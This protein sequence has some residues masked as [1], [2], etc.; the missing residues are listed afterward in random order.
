MPEGKPPMPDVTIDDLAQSY[1]NDEER[2]LVELARCVQVN[3]ENIRP[4]AEAHALVGIAWAQAM[5]LAKL[6][7]KAGE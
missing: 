6:V 5:G 1:V 4:V 7:E 2:D 3:L